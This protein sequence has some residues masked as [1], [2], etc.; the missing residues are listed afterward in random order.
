MPAG[1]YFRLM[2]GG[3]SGHQDFALDEGVILRPDECIPVASAILALFIEH[4]DRTDRKKARLKYILDRW[5]HAKF[6]EEVEATGVDGF[7][8]EPHLTPGTVDDVVEFVL[9]ALAARG[10]FDG[11]AGTA[12]TLRER[13]F[14]PGRSQLP[15]THRGA[16]FRPTSSTADTTPTPVGS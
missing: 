13:L 4:G 15:Q 12:G 9:P 7:L 16:G 10:L 14:G 6:V 5:G 11:G 8:L 2:I 3:I 1:V